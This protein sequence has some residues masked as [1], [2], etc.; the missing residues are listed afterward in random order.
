MATRPITPRICMSATCLLMTISVIATAKPD[1]RPAAIPLDQAIN[2][3]LNLEYS[4]TASLAIDST[5]GRAITVT[6]PLEKMSYTLQLEPYSVRSDIYQVLMQNDQGELYEVPAGPIRTLRGSLVEF[7]GSV[8]AGSLMEDGLYVRIRMD[9]G[10][11]YWMEPVGNKVF[12]APEDLYVFYRNDDIIPSGGT[13]AAEDYMEVGRLLELQ[14]NYKQN[15]ASA[16]GLSICTAELGVDTD[17]EYFQDWGSQTESR[18]NQVINAVNIQYESQVQLSHLITTVIVRS[19]S[20]DPY[21]TNSPSGLLEQFRNEWENNQGAI[22]RDIAHMFTGRNLSG[23]VIGIAWLASVCSNFAY[24]LAES[25]CCGS[26]ACTTDLT[27]HELGHGWAAGHCNCPNNTM[28]PTIGCT[29]NFSAGSINTMQAFA[30]SIN[31]LTCADPSPTG[32]C[33]VGIQCVSLTQENCQNGGGIYQG[34][35]VPCNANTCTLPVGG[36]CVNDSC[37]E[38]EELECSNAGGDYAGDGTNCQTISCAPGACCVGIDCS[39]ILEIDCAGSW[40]G[41]GTTCG[42]ITCGAGTDELNSVAAFW[43]RSDGQP[44]VTY[45]LFFPSTDPNT[46]LVSVF[47]ENADF[48]QM[49][50]WSNALFNGSAS[51][52]AFHQSGFGADIPHDRSLDPFFDD[53]LVFDSYVTIGSDDAAIGIPLLLGFDTSG[54]N[55]AS[56]VSMNNGIWFV[57]PDDPMASIGAGTVQG[58]RVTSLSVEANQGIEVLVNIQ[59]FD[60]ADVIHESRNIYWNNE[61]VTT[62]CPT[63][64]NGSG[65]TDVSDLL[66]VIGAWGPCSGC[67]EDLDGSGTVDVTDLLMVIGAWGP[68]P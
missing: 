4:W 19:S 34:D 63:D 36:C 31:C 57:I 44:M 30:N 68:C 65:A 7:G 11:E 22:V 3:A 64:I 10:L 5:P 60:G 2:N 24:G 53:D 46:R 13:C 6:I 58:H 32:A 25:D 43:S 14:A 33:C 15:Q 38:L 52:V 21:T 61:G 23:G 40:F 1:I 18:I 55:S 17:F 54:F 12:G 27:A 8:V 42:D 51:Q 41:E 29:N 47:G 26:F 49:R 66:M 9:D 39:V 16:R 45:D 67:P 48:L 62:P 20:N 50:G 37:V 28:N 59:W 35:N 56:G